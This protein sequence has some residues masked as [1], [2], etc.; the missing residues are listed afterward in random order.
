MRN[1]MPY[2]MVALTI[3]FT[4]CGQFL[5][6]W[7]VERAGAIPVGLSQQ[8]RF[9]I[10]LLLNP[11]VLAAFASA[12]IASITWMLAMTKLPLSHAH[13]MTS[14]TFVVVVFGSA[15]FFNEPVTPLKVAGLFLI[16]VGVAIGSQG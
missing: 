10:D 3:L 13:P 5:I 12:F 1:A 7:Q 4:V 16:L 6:K 14:L 9:C 15:I 8:I 2:L 11:W